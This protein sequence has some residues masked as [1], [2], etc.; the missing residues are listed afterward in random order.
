MREWAADN[1]GLK[2][3]HQWMV[4]DENGVCITQKRRPELCRIKPEIQKG[5][6]ILRYPGMDDH[7]EEG[8]NRYNQLS[9]RELEDEHLSFNIVFSIQ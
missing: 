4:V 3:D 2:Y 5:T 9:C 8:R 7:M 6:L 1:K